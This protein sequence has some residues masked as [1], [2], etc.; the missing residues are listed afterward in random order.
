[1]QQCHRTARI[2]LRV[3]ISVVSRI[4][5]DRHVVAESIAQRF[6]LGVIVILAVAARL[7]RKAIAN[8]HGAT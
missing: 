4:K 7:I 8:E 1:M 5:C 3:A 6:W 2:G